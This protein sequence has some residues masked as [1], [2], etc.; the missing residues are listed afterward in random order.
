[1]K[2]DIVRRLKENALIWDEESQEQNGYPSDTATL[3]RHAA[4]EIEM[5]R[6]QVSNYE[7]LL[8]IQNKVS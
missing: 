6:N 8:G 2:F 3:L 4:R 5:L 7:H 1:M